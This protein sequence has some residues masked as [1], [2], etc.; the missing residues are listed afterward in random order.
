MKTLHRSSRKAM[1]AR[2]FTLLELAVVAVIVGILATALLNRV[3]YYQE[4]AEKTAMEQTLGTLRSAL[5][6]QIADILVSGN[7]AGLNRLVDQNPMSWLS[8]KP[9]NYVGEY[10]A[11]KPGLV[12]PGNWYFDPHEKNLVYLVSNTEHLHTAP[13][14]ANRLRFSVKLVNGA[15]AIAATSPADEAARRKAIVGVVLTPTIAYTWF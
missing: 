5:H 3:V 4:Q 9:G 14:E 2:G 13:N 15:N 10:Y 6:L 12:G 7:T 1:G 8:E 11:P